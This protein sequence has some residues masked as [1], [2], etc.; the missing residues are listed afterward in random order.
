MPEDFWQMCSAGM[1]VFRDGKP[2]CYHRY[3]MLGERQFALD[4]ELPEL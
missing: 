2:F 1:V 4:Q 3:H